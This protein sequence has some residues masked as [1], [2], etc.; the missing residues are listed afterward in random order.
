MTEVI[1]MKK[2]TV[3]LMLA[4]LLS[5]FAFAEE[6]GAAAMKIPVSNY[7]RINLGD[8]GWGAVEW[9]KTTIDEYTEGV[10]LGIATE[11]GTKIG[12]TMWNKDY[13]FNVSVWA[14]D[15]GRDGNTEIFVSGDIASDDY[16]TYCLRYEKGE[17]VEIPFANVERG[18]D[19]EGYTEYGYG[20]VTGFGENTVTL[21]GTQDV[22]GTYF[23]SRTFALKDNTF[24][25][26]DNGLWVFG[27]YEDDGWRDGIDIA[28]SEIWEY[29]ALKAV[30]PIPVAFRSA[31]GHFF[32]TLLPG[33]RVILTASDC[34]TVAYFL[35]EDGREGCFVLE[36]N[37]DSWGS[38]IGG[39]PENE[40]FE[41][42]PYA[43]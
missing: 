36:P 34:A 32:S 24:E 22:L 14:A 23:G 16:Y 41:Y 9:N 2:L 19:Y 20:M 7:T 17:I 6:S 40:L 21:T 31:D 11:S 37:P 30:Q 42:I 13:L 5:G 18:S 38:L 26:A 4:V 27:R 29:R 1:E 43:D 3:L 28:D 10:S 33:E 35:T 15:L 12:W 39:I 8:E 25:I